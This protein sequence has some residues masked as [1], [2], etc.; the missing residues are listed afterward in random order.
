MDS[1]ASRSAARRVALRVMSR[2]IAVSATWETTK[3]SA[4]DLI[5]YDAPP[6]T[7]TSS[8][9]PRCLRAV[10]SSPFDPVTMRQTKTR[11]HVIPAA[12][13]TSGVT[14]FGSMVSDSSS[15]AAKA[16]SGPEA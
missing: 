4:Y 6:A 11:Y 5:K 1:S 15:A 12:T 16:T 9:S 3:G 8:A 14:G 7:P 2:R 13:G 10:T